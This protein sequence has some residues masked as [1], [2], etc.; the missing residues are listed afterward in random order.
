MQAIIQREKEAPL[1]KNPGCGGV[2]TTRPGV[3]SFSF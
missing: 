2:F 3:I 1:L